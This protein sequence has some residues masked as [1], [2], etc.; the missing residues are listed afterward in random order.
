MASPTWDLATEHNGKAVRCPLPGAQGPLPCAHLHL[1]PEELGGG[2]GGQGCCPAGPAWLWF[3]LKPQEAP[4]LISLSYG[5]GPLSGGG[6]L[7]EP[8]GMAGVRL[9]CRW[10]QA[11]VDL[12]RG[13]GTLADSKKFTLHR[14][15]FDNYH[16]PSH[17]FR[18]QIHLDKEAGCI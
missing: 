1:G 15:C 9:G 8:P 7:G 16:L 13:R 18:F 3:A 5:M 17:L 14:V 2:G 4:G 6:H 12:G 10:E 11:A